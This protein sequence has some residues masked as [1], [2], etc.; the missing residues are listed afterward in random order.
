MNSV[1]LLLIIAFISITTFVIATEGHEYPNLEEE[2]MHTKAMMQE[3][4]EL[5]EELQLS[6]TKTENEQKS[7][8]QV[9]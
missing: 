4:H 8:G 9:F 2:V 5:I 7:N 3:Q 1:N 6:I